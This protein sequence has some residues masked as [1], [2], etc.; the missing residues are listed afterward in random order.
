MATGG[1]MF[2]VQRKY[3]QPFKIR[4]RATMLFAANALPGSPDHSHGYGSRWVVVPFQTITLAPEQE[5]RGLEARLAAELDGALVKAVAGLR[6]ALGR[7]DY[8]RPASVVAATEA[9]RR[10]SNPL[11]R[12]ADECLEVTGMPHHS[13]ARLAVVDA[14]RAW[15][16]IEGVSHPV[17]SNRLWRELEV[18]DPR[19]DTGTTPSRPNGH[20]AGQVGIVLGVESVDHPGVAL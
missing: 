1:D 9:F 15:C 5:D 12:F 17:A 2:E 3:G 6:R 19:I 11:A 13:V 8:V 18:L 14:Y 4:N 7:G 16:R 20:R 10:D